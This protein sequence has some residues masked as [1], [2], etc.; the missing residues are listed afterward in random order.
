M[1][2]RCTWIVAE[3]ALVGA[4]ACAPVA[5]F[6]PPSALV[7]GDRTFEVGGGGVYVSP[8]PYVVE[9]GHQMGQFW[10]TGRATRW[11]SL[12]AVGGFDAHSALGGGAALARFVTT[13]RFVAGASVEAGFAWGATSLSGAAR[14]FDDTWV[15]AAPRVFNWGKFVA[16]GVPVGASVHVFD[17]FSLRA[18]VQTSWEDL[19]YY[20]RRTHVG[21]AAAYDW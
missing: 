14:L 3:L 15:Y 2:I 19:K 9:S 1:T 20:N 11:L 4:V 18:E 17:G 10:F 7:R 6:R 5:D 13:D 21:A 8:R 12:S 16:V